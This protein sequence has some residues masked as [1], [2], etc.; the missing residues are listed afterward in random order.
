MPIFINRTW[1][2]Y[3]ILVCPGDHYRKWVRRIIH[4]D[5]LPYLYGSNVIVDLTFIPPE[6]LKSN[7]KLIYEW[8]LY[9]LNDSQT[10]KPVKGDIDISPYKK[11]K[12]RLYTEPI[13]TSKQYVLSIKIC[14]GDEI[15]QYED[16]A[17]FTV[18]DRDD[19]FRNTMIPIL[20]GISGAVL[21]AILGAILTILL[22]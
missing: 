2:G 18:Q 20:T 12:L 16:I 10:F 15:G 7:E 21:G 3:K 9:S 22:R 6:N 17:I 5:I 13:L 19:F 1:F 4:Y 14:K 11:N 8:Q